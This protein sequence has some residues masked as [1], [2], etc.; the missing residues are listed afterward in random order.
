MSSEMKSALLTTLSV[1]MMGSF[2]LAQGTPDDECIRTTSMRIYSNAVVSEETGDVSG[3]E[4]A[5]GKP[6]NST[7][8]A[9]LYVYE[10]APNNNGI[11]LEGHISDKTLILEGNW[12]EHLIEYPGKKEIVQHHFVRIN[13]RHDPTWFRGKIT[14]KEVSGLSDDE[15]VRLQHVGHIW[16]CKR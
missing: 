14:I 4:L 6:S 11:Q 15:D 8:V 16:L 12:D 2:G 7:V 10:G 9:R 1:L 13:G 5:V 3:F